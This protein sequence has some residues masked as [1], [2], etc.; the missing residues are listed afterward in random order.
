MRTYTMTRA[1]SRALYIIRFAAAGLVL[2]GHSFSFYQLGPLK[3][4]DYFPY[5]Q[6][7]A[8][9]IFLVLSGFLTAYSIDKHPNYSYAAF[10]INRVKRIYASFLP[11]LAFI[12]I[13][14][15]MMIWL[16]PEIYSHYAYFNLPTLIRNL[17]MI[18]VL[19]N[20]GKV[21]FLNNSPLVHALLVNQPFGSG[22]PL[23]TLFI[24]WNMYVFYGY[25][26]LIIARKHQFRMNAADGVML[27]CFVIFALLLDFRGLLMI[28][29]FLGGVLIEKVLP[30][31]VRPRPI[32]GYF[33]LLIALLLFIFHAVTEKE[34]YTLPMA[35]LLSL[36]IFI[37]L[38]IC[39]SD[40]GTRSVERG[41]LSFLSDITYP[42][43]L[44]HYT[45]IEI[46]ICLYRTNAGLSKGVAFT[47][48]IV[49]SC[50]LAC[51]FH[52]AWAAL[53]RKKYKR[54]HRRIVHYGRQRDRNTASGH[55][56][57]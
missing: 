7:I 23:W 5:I 9:L 50:L 19:P 51:L 35:L 20:I 37:I 44:T 48:G 49:F 52:C 45:V 30:V 11:A 33:F 16:F 13:A 57:R 24:E 40:T 15:G 8:V 38:L 6:S 54:R 56:G 14:D 10:F 43:Y 27:A 34:A 41:V 1:Q 4:Q 21:G 28:L 12:A 2:L 39:Q 32:I 29:C 3:N 25:G 42:L 26:A 46:I 17:F 31:F 55:A 53:G 47:L 22:R 18:P 36:F